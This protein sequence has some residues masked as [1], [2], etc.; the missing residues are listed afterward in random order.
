MADTTRV[1][2][3]TVKSFVKDRLSPFKQL[4]GGVVFVNE[5]PKNAVGKLLRRELKERAKKEMGMDRKH[6]VSQKL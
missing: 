4:R 5:I 6:V 2:E 3:Q 1:N